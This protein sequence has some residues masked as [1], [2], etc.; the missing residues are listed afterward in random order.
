VGQAPRH[1][2]PADLAR[3]AAQAHPPRRPLG[4]RGPARPPGPRRRPLGRRALAE[5]ADDA[6]AAARLRLHRAGARDRLPAQRRPQRTGPRRP[7]RAGAPASRH[8][9]GPHR[10]PV[11]PDVARRRGLRRRR[12]RA[13]PVPAGHR[14]LRPLAGR[15]ARAPPAAALAGAEPARGRPGLARAGRLHPPRHP[16][17]V[18]GRRRPGDR[19][20]LGD[21]RLRGHRPAGAPVHLRPRRL[22]RPGARLLLRPG[23]DRARPAAGH[24]RRGP[25]R[26]ARPRRRRGGERRP[27]RPVPRDLLPPRRRARHRPGARPALPRPGGDHRHRHRHR[28]RRE[29]ACAPLGTRSPPRRPPRRSRW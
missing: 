14:R 10:R 7:A 6:P 15:R 4:A 26:P 13:P 11:R 19:L 12:P 3:H 29:P 16:R 5:P 27:R 17:A 22:P 24:Q 8:P 21:V 2:L 28:H 18:P 23:G 25:R 1:R 9:R 20:L